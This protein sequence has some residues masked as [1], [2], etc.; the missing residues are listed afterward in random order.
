MAL[1][2]AGSSFVGDGLNQLITVGTIDPGRLTSATVTGGLVGG[3]FGAAFRGRTG[4]PAACHSFDPS[5]HVLMADG[6]TKPIK[7]VKLGDEVTSTDPETGETTAEPVTQL[8]VNQDTD[9]TD[10]TV[11]DEA[12]G[13]RAVLHTT[14]NHPFWD[15]DNSEWVAASELKPGAHLLDREKWGT[16][17][18]VAVNVSTGSE[19]MRDLTV[20][21]VHTYYVL[22]GD[23][24]V[25]VHNCGSLPPEGAFGQ[26]TSLTTAAKAQAPLVKALVHGNSRL[27]SKTTYLYRMSDDA[28]NY[29]K[30]G[31]TSNPGSRYT[32]KYLVDK[33]LDF[34]TSG[35][36]SNMLNLERFIVERDPG[37]LNLERWAGDFAGDVP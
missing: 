10:V 30:T 27:S 34:L 1:A 24:P 7:D 28:G 20:D 31:L 17:T 2:G 37:P 32:Q 15:A 35:S 16:Q 6:T 18:I 11:Q 19:E 12:T 26:A 21:T 14:S 23:T 9:L 36:R 22:A 8:H 13:T 29:L 4:P 33:R 3:V 5:T 25:L